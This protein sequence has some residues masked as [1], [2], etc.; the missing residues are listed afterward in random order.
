MAGGKLGL[1][2]VAAGCV[3]G[4][5]DVRWPD[6]RWRDKW[7]DLAMLMGWGGGRV[8]RL[9]CRM[10]RRLRIRLSEVSA[11]GEEMS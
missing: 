3:M 1:A 8:L 9:R 7:P 2:G 11:S 4:Y 5:L 6:Y 10:R